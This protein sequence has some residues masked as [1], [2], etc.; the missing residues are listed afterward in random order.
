MS[1]AHVVPLQN[2]EHVV[3]VF[4]QID[5][6]HVLTFVYG[7]QPTAGKIAVF[8]RYLG[9][10]WFP[11]SEAGSL[12]MITGKA[13]VAVGPI[14][15]YR[16]VISGL[17]GG[18]DFT[19]HIS[20]MARW[21]GPG[22]PSGIFEGNRAITVQDYLSANVKRGAQFE[23]ASLIGSLAAGATAYALFRTSTLPVLVKARAVGFTGTGY[24]ARVYKGPT[25]SGGAPVGDPITVFNLSDRNPNATTVTLQAVTNVLTP[26]TEF[27]APTYGIGT[28]GQ[29]NRP[30]GTFSAPGIE[31]DLGAATDYLL[32]IT[33]NDLSAQKF[34]TYLTWYEGNKDLPIR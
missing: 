5:G 29:G 10:G 28:E 6:Y 25:F 27:G 8:A 1:S 11:V 9:L 30:V 26:G 17:V 21:P 31:R 4:G 20:D 3:D 33:N 15:A 22:F 13:T 34:A 23:A 16:F 7:T 24:T 19:V 32:A 12:D 2:G 14:D 18:A